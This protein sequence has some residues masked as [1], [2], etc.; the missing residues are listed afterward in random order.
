MVPFRGGRR[1]LCLCP[2]STSTSLVISPNS[3]TCIGIRIWRSV[4]YVLVVVFEYVRTHGADVCFVTVVGLA[5]S[6]RC[7]DGVPDAPSIILHTQYAY[8][9]VVVET[10]SVCRASPARESPTWR[11]RNLKCKRLVQ[12][13]SR[14]VRWYILYHTYIFLW[15]RHTKD[16]WFC[17]FTYRRYLID[18]NY[19]VRCISHC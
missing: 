13:E 1:M 14:S 5:C 17:F 15:I 11:P 3:A 8:S 12:C 16:S 2:L 4:Y 6:D 7:R 9:A 10:R 19:A 18:N